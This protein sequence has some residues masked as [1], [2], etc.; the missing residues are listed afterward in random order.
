MR[1]VNSVIT[2]Y[3]LKELLE[4]RE[5]LQANKLEYRQTLKLLNQCIELERRKLRP[6]SNWPGDEVL[7]GM[8]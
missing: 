8:E 7:E 3:S 2:P 1:D 4:L 6:T 5:E